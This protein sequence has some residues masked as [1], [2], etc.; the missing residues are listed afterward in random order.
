MLGTWESRK[1]L[2]YVS[3]Q[4]ALAHAPNKEVTFAI[5]IQ[6]FENLQNK[7]FP[8]EL[9]NAERSVAITDTTSTITG[10]KPYFLLTI[11]PSS[12]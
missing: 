10:Q 3:K 1:K 9:L 8:A 4:F 6:Y 11:F 12:L 7:D 2:K 5:V